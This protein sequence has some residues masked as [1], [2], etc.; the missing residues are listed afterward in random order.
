MITLSMI[1]SLVVSD[2]LMWVA[3]AAYAAVIITMIV[4]VLS[5]NRNP[6]KA[7]GWVT[8]LILFP[9]GGAVLYM[10]FGRSMRNVRM[11]SRR[12]RRRL[13]NSSPRPQLL[14]PG[15]GLSDENK[16]CVM[17]GY[18][19][20]EAMIYPAHNVEI[21]NS[22][23]RMFD[24]LLRDLKE[25][26]SYINLQF[27]IIANDALGRRLADVLIDR[28]RHGVRIRV[29]YD[30]VGSWGDKSL[31]LFNRMRAEGIE[32]HSFF[33]IQLSEKLSRLNW[34]NHRKAVIIDGR[35]GYI[36]GMNVAQRYIDGG[37]NFA[38]WRDMAVRVEGQAVIALQHNFAID[39]KFMGYDLLTDEVAVSE[40]RSMGVGREDGEDIH[41]VTAQ[42]IAS[43]PTDR[44]GNSQMLFL[45][46][47]TGARRRIYIQTPYF[48]PSET[49]QAALQCAA[50]SGV[51]VRLMVPVRSDSAV[52]THASASFVEESLLAGI[53]VYFYRG[54]MLHS[55]M[56]LVDNDF[57]T[58]G[59]TNFDYRSF[60]HNFEENILMYSREVNERVAE[61]FKADQEQSS[62]VKLSEWNQRPRALKV[63]E[64]LCRLLSPIL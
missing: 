40:D 62:Q 11:I 57:V 13:L 63:R 55:K 8:A 2:V 17:L 18:S 35:V 45:R 30:Y 19:L 46:A 6:L 5:E 9:V 48:L 61:L 22:G 52:L 51:D 54:G 14:K 34:R 42:I 20:A 60:E 38:G 41:G 58:I 49:L 50:L 43:G 28:A 27:Y 33:R 24:S 4:A 12:N 53:K 16:R 59:S 29:I 37:K 32:V 44:W 31:S 3:V 56:M 7:L 1:L 26:H 23:E 15:R 21:F 64:S 36:G 25:A 10:V 47:I 39:W